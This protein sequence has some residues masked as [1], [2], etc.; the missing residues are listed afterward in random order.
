MSSRRH[1]RRRQRASNG[2]LFAVAASAA[3]LLFFSGCSSSSCFF[4]PF[5]SAAA[6]AESPPPLPGPNSSPS[7][8]SSVPAS[9]A[10]SEW[11]PFS[12]LPASPSEGGPRTTL[13]LELLLTGPSLCPFCAKPQAAVISVVSNTVQQVPHAIEMRSVGQ[14]AVKLAPG[15]SV[16]PP[17]VTLADLALIDVPVE[18]PRNSASSSSSQKNNKKPSGRRRQRRLQA[19]PSEMLPAALNSSPHRRRELFAAGPPPPAPASPAPA[20]S[21]SSSKVAP[22]CDVPSGYV[23]T[24]SGAQHVT[25]NLTLTLAAS[26][27]TAASQMLQSAAD[28][29]AMIS[30]FAQSGVVVEKVQILLLRDLAAGGAA[31]D[32]MLGTPVVQMPQLPP[33]LAPL[34]NATAAGGARPGEVGVQ[35]GAIAGILAAAVAGTATAV[36]V[37]YKLSTRKRRRSRGRKQGAG[38]PTG[39]LGASDLDDDEL[40]IEAVKAGIGLPPSMGKAG[41]VSGGNI[42]GNM[43]QSS[44]SLLDRDP[45]LRLLNSRAA[46]AAAAAAANG[47]SDD[48]AFLQGASTDDSAA[49]LRGGMG[50][51]GSLSDFGNSNNNNHNNSTTALASADGRAGSGAMHSLWQVNW[52]DLEIVRQIGEGSFGKVYLAKWRET[53]VA[54]KVLLSASLPNEQDGG[55]SGDNGSSGSGADNPLLAGL[56]K[57]ASMMAAM[58]HPNV[59]MYL[60]VCTDPPLVVTEYCARGS[61]CDV[62]KRARSAAMNAAAAASPGNGGANAAAAA[63]AAAALDWPRRLAMALD[64]AKGMNYLHSSDPPVIHRDLKSPNLLV[65]KHWRVKVCDFNLSRVLEEQAVVSSLAASNPRWLAPE[66]LS[67]RGYTFSSDVYSFG[68]IMWELLT[69]RLPWTDCG[70]WQVVKLVTDDR[71]RPPLPTLDADG[72]AVV[73]GTAAVAATP[74]QPSSSGSNGHQQLLPP[75]GG[76]PGLP[77]YIAL[78]K[79]C[80]Q[81]EAEKR[82]KFAEIITRLRKLLLHETRRAA[83]AARRGGSG[84]SDDGASN[85]AAGGGGGSNNE[86][87]GDGTGGGDSSANLPAAAAAAAAGE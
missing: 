35:P 61:L 86:S 18:V 48:S 25:V 41:A 6:G 19:A 69:W 75:P 63:A 17:A 70:P 14:V 23:Y 49:A 85:A 65:D 13:N 10:V 38:G 71:A 24:V 51:S 43:Q 72:N 50:T 47:G 12:S 66:I 9:C 3:A 84:G 77:E 20:P 33:P 58:R 40:D 62:L 31:A 44:S 30:G 57:E 8:S 52:R 81:H 60:G 15:A 26:S 80:W 56:Q 11:P 87:G 4:L 78:M 34:A 5:A 59:V 76:F 28:G 54:V 27:I 32:V 55:G 53:T 1:R 37:V 29:G 82:P 79:D 73:S 42:G 39:A 74:S 22:G 16:A 7:S 64:A 83:A 2:A 67:G 46:A 68:V 21:S 36:A 45:A